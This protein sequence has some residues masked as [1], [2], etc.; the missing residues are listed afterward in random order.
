MI[1]NRRLMVTIFIFL[2]AFLFIS[3][4]C[5][6]LP[7]IGKKKEKD[8]KTPVGKT[9][10]VEGMETIK[11]VNPPKEETSASKKPAA[12]ATLPRK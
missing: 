4:S 1:Q 6:N 9:V 10:T 12:P 2:M 3:N 8:E 7:L 11:G 5:S